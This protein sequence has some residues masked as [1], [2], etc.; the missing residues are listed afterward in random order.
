[1]KIRLLSLAMCLGVLPSA[2]IAADA[3][4]A[5]NLS[6]A[7]IVAK[8]EKSGFGPFSEVSREHGQWE[9]EVQKGR[10]AL[11]LI[12]SSSTGEII[13]QYADDT[14]PQPP[15]GSLALSEV[16]KKV[17]AAGYSDIESVSFERR[18]WEVEAFKGGQEHECQVDPK[19][20]EIVSD[21]LDD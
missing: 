15:S 5:G 1:M 10:D 12:V 17:A 13:S 18:Y 7:D 21:R 20:G 6:I 9:V 11:E 3:P 14:D 16:L 2:V 4:I 8:L 19:T